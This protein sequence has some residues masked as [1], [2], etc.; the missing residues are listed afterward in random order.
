MPTISVYLPKE[1]ADLLSVEEKKRGCSA[2]KILVE[3]FMGGGTV[4]ESEILK[5]LDQIDE[6]LDVV[7]KFSRGSA[8]EILNKLDSLIPKGM[9]EGRIKDYSVG[10]KDE[11]VEPK[12]I[13]EKKIEKVKG[14]D[15]S[16]KISKND[17]A[18][19]R[20]KMEFI[21]SKKPASLTGWVGGFSKEQQ[22][23]KRS[24]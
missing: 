24:K 10:G 22:T 2:A 7:A 3:S 17:E 16:P 19:L 1:V 14:K 20:A 23:G 21:K 12:T 15:L 8:I 4:P 9:P 5:K 6:N 13:K 11:Q 18:M